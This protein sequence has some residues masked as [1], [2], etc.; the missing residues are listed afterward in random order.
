MAKKT[1]ELDTPFK[2]GEKVVAT[3]A[4]REIPSGASGKIQ[5]RS[6]LGTWNR[7]WVNFADYGPVGSVDH[8]DLVRPHQLQDW[9]ARKEDRENSAAQAEAAE[10]EKA[11]ASA[12]GG[13]GG[14]AA[15]LVPAH[16]LERS[17]AAKARL[18]GG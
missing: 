10:A 13:G 3:R 14:G 15:S 2:K 6:G 5:M 18:L 17:R 1:V 7:Y 16:L 11:E 8:D 9:I 12:E 4:L